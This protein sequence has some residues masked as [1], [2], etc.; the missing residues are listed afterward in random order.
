MAGVQDSQLAIAVAQA[1]GLGSIP[2]GTLGPDALRAE[3]ERLQAGTDQPVNVN[4]FCHTPP[5]PDPAVE[6]KWREALRPYFDELD[7]SF[8]DISAGMGR[9]PFN[10]DVADV[11]EPFRPAIVSFHFGL[12][13]LA[14]LQRVKGWGAVVLSTATTIDEALWLAANGADGIIAQGLEAGGHRGAFLAKD[15]TR[16]M[17]T[18][19]LVPQIA[20][21]VALPVVA[22]GGIGDPDGVTAVL[23]LGA[24]AAQ[25]GTAYLLCPE[26]KTSPIHRESLRSENAQHSA[27]TNLFSGGHARGIVN[28]VMREIGPISQLAPPYPLAA[29][30]MTTL[31]RRAEAAGSGDFSPLWS[32]QNNSGCREIPAADL[33]RW[34]AGFD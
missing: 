12:P 25:V 10:H 32:G 17:G 34:L 3:L 20:R 9:R 26:A 19:A 4:F 28:R 33:T 13:E 11:L 21:R 7:L 15:L 24:V 14:L 6:A 8:D 1:G 16:Q 30:A 22:A 31:R 27:I 5:E 18:L 29:A 2:C 23:A